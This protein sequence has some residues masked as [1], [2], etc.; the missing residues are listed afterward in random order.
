M[1]T[2]AERCPVCNSDEIQV[3]DRLFDYETQQQENRCYCCHCGHTWY[4]QDEEEYR[5]DEVD[6]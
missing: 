2:Q 1:Y 5:D 6:A 4:E 3:I